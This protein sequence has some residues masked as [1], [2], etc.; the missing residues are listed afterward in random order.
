MGR[1]KNPFKGHRFPKGIILLAV[2]WNCRYPLSYRDVRDLL[3]ERGISVDA[4]TNYRWV[5]KF[6]PEIRSRSFGQHRSWRGLQW[7]VDET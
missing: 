6:G 1:R 3:A 4:A 2:C 7:H 5:Q